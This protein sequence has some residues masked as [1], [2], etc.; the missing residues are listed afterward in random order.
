LVIG[1]GI[2][3]SQILPGQ[4]MVGTSDFALINC[5]RKETPHFCKVG[6]IYEFML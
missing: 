2:F 3:L 4:L 5:F 1:R 6:S